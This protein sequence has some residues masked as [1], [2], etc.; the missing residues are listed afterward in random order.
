[1][2]GAQAEA[3]AKT[4]LERKHTRGGLWQEVLHNTRLGEA[5]EGHHGMVCTMR[6]IVCEYR[7]CPLHTSMAGLAPRTSK[8]VRVDGFPLKFRERTP[9]GIRILIPRN[10]TES[11]SNSIHPGHVTAQPPATARAAAPSRLLITIPTITHSDH[12]TQP[13]ATIA[14]LVAACRA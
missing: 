1:M 8:V 13:L 11:R 10:Y 4:E 9:Q 7:C 12:P 14:I 6:W 3:E 5:N 2:V